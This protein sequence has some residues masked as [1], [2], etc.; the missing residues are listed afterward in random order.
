MGGSL[1]EFIVC[2]FVCLYDIFTVFHPAFMWAYIIYICSAYKDGR[3]TALF[4]YLAV[5][6]CCRLELLRLHKDLFRYRLRC[7]RLSDE[8]TT[9]LNVH[10][11]RQ[12]EVVSV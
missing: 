12:L 5:L 10:R 2:L 4:T 6:I 8:L 9:P 7:Q 3:S 1:S 11:W